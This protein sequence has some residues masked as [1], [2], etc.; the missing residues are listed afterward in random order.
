M[1]FSGQGEEAPK[2]KVVCFL[3][4]SL[5]SSVGVVFRTCSFRPGFPGKL[6]LATTLNKH[7]GRE[8]LELI[9][10]FL[11]VLLS[12]PSSKHLEHLNLL[13]NGGTGSSWFDVKPPG[14]DGSSGGCGWPVS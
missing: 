5:Q 2:A 3:Q 13:S 6:E 12:C 10:T 14:V 11:I 4:L 7:L 8:K 1:A 9:V